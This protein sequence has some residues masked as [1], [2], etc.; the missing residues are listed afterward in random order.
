MNETKIRYFQ[1]IYEEAPD[2]I[3]PS[4]TLGAIFNDRISQRMI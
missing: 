3:Q 2:T 4:I 1:K